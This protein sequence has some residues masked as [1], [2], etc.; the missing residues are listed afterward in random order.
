MAKRSLVIIMF[1]ILG[2]TVKYTPKMVQHI[3]GSI[4]KATDTGYY[5]TELVMKP[6]QPIVGQNSA[7]LIIHNYEAEDIPGLWIHVTPYLPAKEIQ[8]EEKPK[9]TD[10]GRGLYLIENIYFPVPGNWELRL[11]ITSPEGVV[12]RVTLS[13]PEVT[14]TSQEGSSQ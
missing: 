2:C 1:L 14:G 3:K 13:L 11:K 5:T 4:F 7:R 8:S 9:V 6:K 10:A 12:D